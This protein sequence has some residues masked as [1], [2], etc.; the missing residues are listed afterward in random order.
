MAK[1]TRE[2]LKGRRSIGGRKL[3]YAACNDI[4]IVVHRILTEYVADCKS[5]YFHCEHPD[6]PQVEALVKQDVT[7][8]DS[9]DMREWLF[10]VSELIP[11]LWD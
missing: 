2:Y 11:T 5:P 8:M 4:L 1:P 10:Q 6:L 7:N 3:R 9:R